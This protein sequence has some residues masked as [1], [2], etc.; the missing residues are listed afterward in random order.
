[1]ENTTFAEPKRAILSPMDM[2][3][4]MKSQVPSE[5][6]M[7]VELE[8]NTSAP[9]FQGREYPPPYLSIKSFPISTKVKHE[10]EKSFLWLHSVSPASIM[11]CNTGYNQKLEV[12]HFF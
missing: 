6:I 3:K 12:L 4:W 8:R 11:I 7:T 10:E 9:Y 1:M 2:P 5:E